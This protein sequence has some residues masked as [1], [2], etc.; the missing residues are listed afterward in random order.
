[1]MPVAALLTDLG[2]AVLVLDARCHGRSDDSRVASMPAFADDVEAAVQWL[3]KD[4]GIDP[5]RVVL[6]GHSVGAGACLL[7]ASRNPAVAGVLSLA[8]MAHPREFM[9][10]AF[11]RARMPSFIVSVLLRAVEHQIRHR[12][13]TF[14]PLHTI[15]RVSA[16]VLIVHGTDDDV[17]P[18]DDAR[19]LHARAGGSA[20]LLVVPGANHY[21]VDSLR[22]VAGDVRAWLDD[23]GV[24]R[25]DTAPATRG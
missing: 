14:A 21:S 13:D 20:H 22:R 6:A 5:R 18:V 4:E 12:F 16:P 3:V 19:R 1:M 9:T 2:L 24:L 8:S 17:V 15:A 7:V 10:G 25:P 23:T 11:A